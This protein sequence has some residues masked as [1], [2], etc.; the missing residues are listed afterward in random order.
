VDINRYLLREATALAQQAGLADTIAFQEGHAYALPFPDQ[1]VD[2]T[3]SVTVMEE[4]DADQ[5]L[6]EMVRVTKPGGRVA[7]IVRAGD[8]PFL[9]NLSLRAALHRSDGTHHLAPW[10]RSLLTTS[11]QEPEC[12]SAMWVIFGS[13][14]GCLRAAITM[15]R[16]T[17]EWRTGPG[18]LGHRGARLGGNRF[19]RPSHGQER[20]LAAHRLPWQLA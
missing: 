11:G 4:V 3:L 1:S 13:G 15:G 16:D 5:M 18:T 10:S 9:M 14:R 7:A 17:C 6:G 8:R 12:R 20:G 2:V 19:H